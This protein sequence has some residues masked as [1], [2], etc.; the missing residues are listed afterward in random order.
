M[1]PQQGMSST[2]TPRTTIVGDKSANLEARSPASARAS[3]RRFASEEGNSVSWSEVVTHMLRG[4]SQTSGSDCSVLLSSEE[5]THR[6]MPHCF[7]SH[8][9]W[10]Q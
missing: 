3:H 4:F 9:G 5:C 8:C 10:I 6:G 7:C 2:A 1:V